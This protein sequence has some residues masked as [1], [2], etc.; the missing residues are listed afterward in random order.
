MPSLG[1]APG[2]LNPCMLFLANI[3]ESKRSPPGIRHIASDAAAKK[4]PRLSH[5]EAS[6]TSISRR[7]ASCT[8]A[9][10]GSVCPASR[11][12]NSLPP[13]A[14]RCFCAVGNCCTYHNTLP[15]ILPQKRTDA[16]PA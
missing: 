5:R 7:Y 2:R 16:A 12:R 6:F 13:Y 8:S 9:V 4:R 15:S 1:T 11:N 10:A 14:F 3:S